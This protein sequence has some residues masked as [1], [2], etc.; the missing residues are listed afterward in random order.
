MT[1]VSIGTITKAQGDFWEQTMTDLKFL[2]FLKTTQKRGT[3]K[4][5]LCP[6]VPVVF[7]IVRRLL[8]CG[9]R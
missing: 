9:R 7:F 5:P 8:P 1:Q 6:Y 2:S 4:F 3:P